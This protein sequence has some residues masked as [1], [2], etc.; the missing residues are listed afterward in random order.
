[1]GNYQLW[2]GWA[3]WGRA[4]PHHTH[5]EPLV[6]LAYEERLL[7]CSTAYLGYKRHTWA[8]FRAVHNAGRTKSVQTAYNG[9]ITLRAEQINQ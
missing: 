4:W 3:G 2:L 7:C 6:D 1:M 5:R 9:D 8:G